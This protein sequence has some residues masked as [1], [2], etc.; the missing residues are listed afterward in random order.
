MKEY[1]VWV[2]E[3]EKIVSFHEVDNSELIYF[4][5]REIYLA[6]LSA[7][8]TQ[9]SV[10]YT[11]LTL[12]LSILKTAIIWRRNAALP[13]SIEAKEVSALFCRARHASG[14]HIVFEWMFRKKRSTGSNKRSGYHPKSVCIG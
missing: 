7:L 12:M 4:D 1:S 3:A 6:Y 10:S 8:T 5:Q 13:K 2:D 11:H 9:G 14:T